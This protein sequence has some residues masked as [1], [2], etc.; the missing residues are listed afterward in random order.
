MKTLTTM[1]GFMW[2]QPIHKTLIQMRVIHL[3]TLVALYLW[4]DTLMDKTLA[5]TAQDAS[6]E[7]VALY[8][9]NFVTLVTVFMKS[10]TELRKDYD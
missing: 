8:L 4:L 9:T 5:L 3:M 2:S 1:L 10:V 6:V 7:L